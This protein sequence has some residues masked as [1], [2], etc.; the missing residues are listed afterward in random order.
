MNETRKYFENMMSLYDALCR[1]KEA[2]VGKFI[3]LKAEIHSL[4]TEIENYRLLE[5]DLPQKCIEILSYEDCTILS[6]EQSLLSVNLA[7]QLSALLT[8]KIWYG[9]ELLYHLNRLQIS[10]YH[11]PTHIQEEIELSERGDGG[12]IKLKVRLHNKEN[13]KE[14]IRHLEGKN[15]EQM[16]S[17]QGKYKELPTEIYNKL[18]TQLKDKIS[19]YRSYVNINYP[20]ISEHFNYNKKLVKAYLCDER[21]DEIVCRIQSYNDQT[22]RSVYLDKNISDFCPRPPYNF[23]KIN[24]SLKSWAWFGINKSDWNIPNYI[25][26]I[27]NIHRELLE[28]FLKNANKNEIVRF[29]CFLTRS[30]HNN[31]EDYESGLSYLKISNIKNTELVRVIHQEELTAEILDEIILTLNSK[32]PEYEKQVLFTSKPDDL[33]I[34][35][36]EE[37]GIKVCYIRN[38]T[39]PHFENENSEFIHL[40]I[41]SKLKEM[42]FENP[43]D[44]DL[45]NILIKDLKDCPLGKEGWSK[46]E[47][48]ASKIFKYLF[49]ESFL[50]FLYETQSTNDEDSLRRDM[51]IHNNYKEANSFWARVKTDYSA[52]L[53]IVEFKNYKEEFN[54]DTMH[55]TTKYLKKKVGNVVI[56][57]SRKGAKDKLLQQQ[58]EMLQEGKLILCFEEKELIEMIEEKM[59]GT[60][61]EYRLDFKMFELLKK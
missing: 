24:S 43:E 56:I 29:Y 49:H 39:Q 11:L 14:A 13:Q 58:K 18:S 17:T 12:G 28:I 32:H 53:L 19:D 7:A 50:E 45:G 34:K 38:F 4:L 52:K 59:S 16:K 55:S 61:P 27:D 46:F 44:V 40:Y 36:F 33:I 20:S 5:I 60:N 57:F 6:E 9:G 8:G 25:F 37:N 22:D 21:Q 48:V 47:N 35:K 51:I 41:Q 1:I 15:I 26:S 3:K 23:E 54:Y 31:V 2:E 42:K 30:L 10:T